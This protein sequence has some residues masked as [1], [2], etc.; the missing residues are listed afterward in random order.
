MLL[1]F[2]SPPKT[3]ALIFSHTALHRTPVSF[4]FVWIGQSFKT[5]HRSYSHRTKIMIKDEMRLFKKKILKNYSD[6]INRG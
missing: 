1:L 3:V 5:L 4:H 2:S 6:E